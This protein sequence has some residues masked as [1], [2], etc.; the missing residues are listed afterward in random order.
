M[1]VLH[2]IG[3]RPTGGIGTVVKNYQLN[4]DRKY[5]EFDYLIFN[6]EKDGAFDQYVTQLGSK[7]YVL[8]ELKNTRL[9][10]INRKIRIFFKEHGCDY[11]V[12]HLH[13]ANIGFMVFVHARNNGVKVRVLHSHSTKYSEK[14][15]NGIRNY[16]LYKSSVYYATD[17]FYCS[18]MA[19]QFL[20]PRINKNLYSMHN[21]IDCK[22]YRFDYETRN[23]MRNE[24]SISN[25][26]ITLISTSRFTAEKNHAFIIEIL[27]ELNK[28]RVDFKMIFVGDGELAPKIKGKV[29]E[30]NLSDKVLFLGYRNDVQKLLSTSDIFLLPSLHEGLPLSIVE[31]Q[32]N[33]VISIV[34]DN[35]TKEIKF[36]DDLCY[37]ETITDTLPWVIRILELSKTQNINRIDR[38]TAYSI[39][40]ENH[41]DIEVEAKKL[42]NRYQI[43][44]EREENQT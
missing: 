5:C 23:I 12:V 1:R 27:N 42:V 31:A 14:K 10:L 18:N 3:K 41:Y 15:I 13:S 28:R 37:F 25:N 44:L 11:D 9:Y 8:P 33:G 22:K 7:V 35:V 36:N 34:S 16:F 17:Y 19:K 21:A 20:F 24:L 38:E 43:I 39:V 32:C 26:C 4:V 30:Y 40:R 2:V 6:D 29:E